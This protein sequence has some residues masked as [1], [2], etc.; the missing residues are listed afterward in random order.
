M[1]RPMNR[2][3]QLAGG[4]VLITGASS[5]IGRACA[6]AFATCGANLVLAARRKDR[7]DAL[8]SELIARG[9]QA[10]AVACDLTVESQ[11]KELIARIDE[12]FNGLDVLVNNAGVGLFGPL[13]KLPEEHLRHVFELNVF[14]LLRMTREALPLLRRRSGSQVINVSSVLGHR[15][16]PLLGGYCASKAAVNAITES[17]R[18]ELQPEG[19]WVLLVSPGMTESEF[20]D[21]R[22]TAPG[23]AQEK[24]PLKAMSAE[25]VAEAIVSA[26][27]SRRRDTVL[28]LAG[29]AMV[30]ANRLS[31]ALFD[32]V[33]RRMVGPPKERGE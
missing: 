3:A 21:V 15:G 24:V 13:E 17:L 16:L 31:P 19:I 33:A 25:E 7:L 22:L 27:R 8:A 26:S 12:R 1:R 23:F 18:S 9:V 11:V 2:S 30:Y 20:R 28:T 4:T 14:G 10:L 5:G 32:R 29:R 6:H